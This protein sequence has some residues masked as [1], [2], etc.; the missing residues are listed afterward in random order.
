MGVRTAS[1]SDAFIFSARLL[2]RVLKSK[3]RSCRISEAA[4]SAAR[5]RDARSRNLAAQPPFII[6]VAATAATILSTFSKKKDNFFFFKKNCQKRGSGGSN[7]N[8]EGWLRCQ[9]SRLGV[10]KSGSSGSC[11]Q[12]SGKRHGKSDRRMK[13]ISY[14]SRIRDHIAKM[15]L[16]RL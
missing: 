13:R 5:F 8:Y 2:W 1:P 14:R 12:I 16:F 10:P 7:P 15:A 11:C 9:I 4:A 3:I 6:R